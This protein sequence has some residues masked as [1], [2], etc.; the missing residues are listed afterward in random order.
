VISVDKTT[1]SVLKKAG[2][3]NSRV[4]GMHKRISPASTLGRKHATPILVFAQKRRQSRDPAPLRK[5]KA[6]ADRSISV[7]SSSAGSSGE[8]LT[9]PV[10]ETGSGGGTLS[11]LSQHQILFFTFSISVSALVRALR[12]YQGTSHLFLRNTVS[13]QRCSF[14]AEYGFSQ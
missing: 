13:Y 12:S 7:A 9:Y 14:V 8:D 3:M 11:L 5:E 2:A 4:A 1:L 6:A 10:P